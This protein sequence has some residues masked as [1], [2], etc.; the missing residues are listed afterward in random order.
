VR[1]LLFVKLF[2]DLRITWNRIVLMII[3]M[4]ISLVAFSTMLY[5]YALVD[6]QISRGY[7]STNP[8]SARII[9]DAGVRQDQMDAVLDAARAEPGV[10]DATLRTVSTFQMLTLDGRLSPI[11]LQLF[12][13]APSDPM[14]V[15]RFPVEQG[16]WPPPRGGVLIERDAL[17]F[18][19]LK[20]GDKV[21][22]ASL[23]G[24]PVPPVITG[25]VHDPS[26]APAYE[27][28][29]GYGYVSTATLPLL[30]KPPVLDELAITVA[31]Q[32]GGTMS[33]HHRDVIVHTAL[34]LASRLKQTLG[35]G[36]AQIQMPPPYQHPHQ[37]QMNA[38]LMAFIGVVIGGI[39]VLM[40]FPIF[41]LAGSI[42]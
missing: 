20:V 37:G 3:A 6:P 4:S 2:R 26:L 42:H 35:M 36:I 40:Y 14:R 8:A 30:G 5:A 28:Q 12:I 22:V 17:M 29:K 19:N 1:R 41:E 23:D 21:V 10:I 11:P 24:R 32:P 34:H 38:L 18:L 33:S 9:L 16:S 31:D 39:V 7:L 25:V 15:A 27:E 13:A